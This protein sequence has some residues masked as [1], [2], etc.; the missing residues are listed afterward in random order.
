[1]TD[2]A[3]RL[4]LFARWRTATPARIG[5][6]RCGDGL[7][8]RHLL[9]FQAAHAQARDAVHGVVDWDALERQLSPSDVVR[10]RS[11]AADRDIYL[12]RPDLGRRLDPA[13]AAVLAGGSCD[14]LLVV[15]DGLSAAAVQTWAAPTI[16]EIR[17]RLATWRIGPIVLASQARVALAD[18]IGA[19][20]G[21][22]MAAV[23]IGE[24][25]GLSVAD[26]LG[27][28]LTY[29]PRPGRRDSERNCI[30]NIH[31][32][33]LSPAAAADKLAFLV[34]EGMRLKLTGVALKEN[35][36]APPLASPTPEEDV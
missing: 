25:P 18:E 33:G 28:Y 36:V 15:G 14:L 20:M 12:R 26:S 24:R 7:P 35:F 11:S 32:Q 10:V 5:L 30:S 1:M 29:E 4:D 17:L 8:T 3:G 34:N 27:I 22:S 23:L 16:A 13:D 6:G 21:A 19:Q 9:D 31:A 2:R